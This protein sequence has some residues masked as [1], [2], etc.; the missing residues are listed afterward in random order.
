MV[1]LKIKK[2]S[3]TFEL[4]LGIGTSKTCPPANR[5]EKA[6]L[7]TLAVGTLITVLKYV[8]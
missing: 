3:K 6:T 2:T 8:V 1:E 5:I 7:C 4:T